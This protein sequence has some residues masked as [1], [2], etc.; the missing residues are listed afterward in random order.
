MEYKNN[1]ESVIILKGTHTEDGYKQALNE[2]I[3]E[4][5]KLIEIEKIDEKGLKKLAYEVNKQKT[6]Y[7]VV[8]YY[9]STSQAILEMERYFRITEDVIKFITVKHED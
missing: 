8:I 4:L 5:K 1:Y 7:F 9:K 6:G 2:I 3:Q